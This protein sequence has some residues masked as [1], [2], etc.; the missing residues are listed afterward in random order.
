LIW[1]T[2][3]LPA[4]LEGCPSPWYIGNN[5]K[6]AGLELTPPES[7]QDADT[8]QTRSGLS[9][10]STEAAS[11]FDS[12][13]SQIP[14]FWES[15]QP[16]TTFDPC[17]PQRT[18]DL[19]DPVVDDFS[20]DGLGSVS[21]QT[22]WLDSF[23]APASSFANFSQHGQAIFNPW[24]LRGDP[25]YLAGRGEVYE[26]DLPG[27]ANDVNA[28]NTMI[29]AQP[30]PNGPQ[31]MLNQ[32]ELVDWDSNVMPLSSPR[33]DF[34]TSSGLI[35]YYFEFVCQILSCFDSHENPFR[36]DIPSMMLT[37]DYLHDCV[38]GMSAAHLANSRVG[39]KSIAMK[40]QA[41]AMA[42]L[43]NVIQT[44]QV[45]T[46]GKGIVTSPRHLSSR[47]ARYQALLAAM[48]LGISS[49]S[50][51]GIDDPREQSLIGG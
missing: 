39:M 9:P 14:E 29:P 30:L 6:S 24:T 10:A 12:L 44:M 25:G 4:A 50:T 34:R 45:A 35:M 5:D 49:V 36:S 47:S 42:G 19:L 40:H 1:K 41:R 18:A 3:V 27:D 37:C 46:S 22:D 13:Q 17:L 11:T 32:T 2:K 20:L 31:L 26:V 28:D 43:S 8:Q 16:G 23:V 15:A 51:H 38:V 21:L 33:L 48:L 7:T